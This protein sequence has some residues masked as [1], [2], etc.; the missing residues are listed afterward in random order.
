[1]SEIRYTLG[2]NI[3]IAS[4][5]WAVLQ[6]DID[7]EPCKI[8]D[9][10]T[11]IFD[12]AEHPKDGSSLAAPR[13]E[14]RSARRTIRRRRHRK[15]RIRYLIETEGIMSQEEIG[16][17]FQNSGFEKSV[18]E[19]RAFALDHLIN[20]E[21]LVRLLIH[22][23]QRRG[24]RSSSTSEEA[25]DEKEAGEVK[26]AISANRERMERGGYRTVGEMY[27]LDPAFRQPAGNEE[28]VLKVRNSPGDYL[29]TQERSEI[30]KEIRLVLTRQI[31]LGTAVF[32][33][34]FIDKYLAIFE[35]QRNFDEG[36]GGNSPYGG[37]QISKMVG[38]CT[39]EPEEDRAP[40][41]SFTFE[42]FRLLQTLNHLRIVQKDGTARGLTKE[43]RSVITAAVMK[44]PGLTY[45]Q[46]REK[47]AMDE[48]C[49]FNALYYGGKSIEEQEKKK[50]GQMQAY[51]K[52]RLALS[53]IRKDAIKS[54]TQSQLDTIAWILSVYKSDSNRLDA[55]KD[56]A[57]PEEFHEALLG[58]SF[59]GF[60]N[61]SIKAM[62]KLS[63]VLEDGV[64]YDKA[65]FAEYGQQISTQ[66]RK[67]KL[68]I[69]DVEPITNPVV[70][71]AVSQAIKVINAVVRKYGPPELVRIELQRELDHS[72]KERGKITK[73]QNE[74]QAANERIREQIREF[75]SGEPTGMD[76][77]KFKLYQEQ[78]GICLYSGKQLDLAHLFDVGYADVGYIIPYSLS[79]DDSY[80]NKVLVS[81]AENRMKGDRIPYDCFGSDLVKWNRFEGLVR[82]KVR[83]V[84]KQ[85]NL[86]RKT[87]TE[88]QIS[89]F[90]KRNLVDTQYLARV[91]HRLLNEH[92]EFAPTAA[93]RRVETVN[94]IITSQ[95]CKRL[96]VDKLRDNGDTRYAA[97]AVIV[98]CITPSMIRRITQYSMLCERTEKTPLGYVDRA[99][100]ELLSKE[101]FDEKYYPKFPEP[102]ARFRQELSARMSVAPMEEITY[103]SLPNYESDEE[104]HPIFVSRKANHKVSG[105]A[106]KETI[107]SGKKE[108]C[109]VSKTPLQSLK[110]DK[111][112]EIAGYYNAGSDRLLY[113]AL[114]ERLS[115]FNG[116]AVKAFAEP[117]Y[118]PKSDGTPGP[119]V[120][121]VKIQESA[122]I[123]QS[124]NG[125]V[126]KNQTMVRTDVYYVEG[127]GYY[128]VPIY[129]ADTVKKELPNRAIIANKPYSEWLEMDEGDFL[130]SLHPG[131]PIF[132]ECKK[133]TML[134]AAKWSN[135]E[136]VIERKSGLF[137]YA[138]CN[139][140]TGSISFTTHD[141]NYSGSVGAKTLPFLRKYQVGVL[142][143]CSPVKLP[144]KRLGFCK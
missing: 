30:V 29:F 88:D 133:S 117:F 89:N 126:A 100:G 26:K 82:S 20:K 19:L 32:K 7:R 136:P 104:I 140:A 23:A 51:H 62:K 39:F 37:N 38:R 113:E 94:G 63:I 9:L 14:A 72:F 76:I 119:R 25:K 96:G 66:Q 102:W 135:V 141:R 11:R 13:R 57:I 34:D 91:I 143:E 106:H 138:G 4:V 5:G 43:Q 131:D 6:N 40:K 90:K 84:R 41:A 129:V 44:S 46:I 144:E 103:H 105:A 139:I 108:G 81:S 95:V 74:N 64:T 120:D 8:I 98:G 31:E 77:V 10:G 116:D 124:V 75:K 22:Y 118:K 114:R 59:S 78:D 107:Y 53:K 18:Y 55:L 111:D 47:L 65:V 21:E 67:R 80:Q 132:I 28:L 130:F 2:L 97:D 3:G 52:M 137:Y 27:W 79:F 112:G 134:A 49:I 128:L 142:G 71:R 73:R 125:G 17:L 123:T 110:L 109:T 68:S 15:E 33:P 1:M 87:L 16:A 93:K 42:Y 45:G 24:Y 69:D 99:T 60:G 58:L 85:N 54:L 35:S 127:K 92:L 50:F 61:L 115:A 12:K 56:A 48:D 83:N 101:E 121:K 36:P 122:T 70:L 86:L